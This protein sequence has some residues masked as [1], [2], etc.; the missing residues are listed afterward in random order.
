MKTKK[1][2]VSKLFC[3]GMALTFI[4]SIGMFSASAAGNYTDTAFTQNYNG[5]GSDVFTPK[6]AKLDYTSSYVYNKNSTYGF[7]T[8][9]YGSNDT[10]NII[11][12]YA[13]YGPSVHVSKGQAKYLPNLVKERGYKYAQIGMMSDSHSPSYISILWSP[14]SI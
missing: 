2:L 8:N 5:D 14:D 3:V 1:A 4:M 12:A 11:G 7:S 10:S 9:V 13:T 6:R